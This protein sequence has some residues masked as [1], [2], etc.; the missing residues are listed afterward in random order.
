MCEP[1]R[2]F[3]PWNGMKSVN[4]RSIIDHWV[5]WSFYVWLFDQ[6]DFFNGR[7]SI[8]IDHENPND[9]NY[10]RIWFTGTPQV[11]QKA[12]LRPQKVVVWC[13]MSWHRII[14]PFFF[15][16]T[17]NA[18]VYQGIIEQFIAILEL[19]ECHIYFQQVGTRAHTAT[20]MIDFLQE[21]FGNWLVPIGLWSPYSPDLTR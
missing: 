13:A 16:T 5:Y 2:P 7:F 6:F 4:K 14:D 19:D 17:M 12:P 11:H 18:E 15:T 9:R 10:C 8:K 3:T 1:M 20:T 21:F